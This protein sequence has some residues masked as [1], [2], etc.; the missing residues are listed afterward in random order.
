MQAAFLETKLPSHERKTFYNIEEMEKRL[1]RTGREL[2]GTQE[3]LDSAT[4]RRIEKEILTI[5]D[6]VKT[7]YGDRS[8]GHVYYRSTNEAEARATQ[9]E[10]E[11]KELEM[12]LQ[13][14]REAM[15]EYVKRLNEKV[16]AW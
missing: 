14:V 3:N 9:L 8:F 11:K 13:I 4:L 10:V 6:I 15:S 7:Q 12:K 16:S 5:G 2:S 1:R